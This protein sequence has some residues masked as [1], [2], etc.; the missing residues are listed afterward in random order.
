MAACMVQS[1]GLV[2]EQFNNTSPTALNKKR[3]T[4]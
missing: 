4:E 1:Q 2:D 3:L